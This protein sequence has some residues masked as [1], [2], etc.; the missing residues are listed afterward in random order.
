MLLSKKKKSNSIYLL[1]TFQ[2]MDNQLQIKELRILKKFYNMC[3][4]F[5]NMFPF[6]N[7]YYL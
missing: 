5:Y 7:Y 6:Y 3:N 2:E 4:K 1:H